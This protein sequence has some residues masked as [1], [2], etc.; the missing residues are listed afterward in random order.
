[1]ASSFSGLPSHLL[2]SPAD[3]L[4]R[5]GELFNDG[6]LVRSIRATLLRMIGGF[7]V[8]AVLGLF[9]GV[10]MGASAAARDC[11][12]SLLLGLQT[13]PSAAWV[14]ISL[15]AFGLTDTSIYFV[16]VMSS[17]GGI[18]VAVA[19]G[20][21]NV[22]PLFLRAARTLGTPRYAITY[23]VVLPAALPSIVT[24]MK[25]GWTLG[26]HGAVSAELIRST[27]GLGFLLHMGRELNDAAQVVAIMLITI[28]LGLLIDKSVFGVIEQRVRARRGLGAER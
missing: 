8:S 15:L 7:G 4:R 23:R 14:P 9:L 21:A 18:A 22:P 25:L 3:V 1:M 28:A 27:L 17:V 2:P 20:I 24:G 19:D 6:V 12:R 13:L 26:W 5:T 16:I 11:L 10:I